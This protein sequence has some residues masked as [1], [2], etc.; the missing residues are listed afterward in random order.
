M[1]SSPNASRL[2]PTFCIHISIIDRNIPTGSITAKSTTNSRCIDPTLYINSSTINRQNT[3]WLIRV[4][5]NGRL[6]FDGSRI[7][8]AISRLLSI[9][10]QR[11]F[12]RHMNSLFH[13]Q[14][15]A[16]TQN[17]INCA[18]HF[19]ALINLSILIYHIPCFTTFTIPR[20][21]FVLNNNHFLR[22]I[23]TYTVFITK[24]TCIRAFCKA[25]ARQHRTQHSTTKYS[26]ATLSPDPSCHSHFLPPLAIIF[27]IL[28]KR[29]H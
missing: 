9:N 26:S 27:D 20:C 1:C 2:R 6:L 18:R 22:N 17:K 24:I 7:Y 19:H 23:I 21:C 15:H 28:F 29:Y 12:A 16:V 4:S 8:S 5:A 10:R 25:R 11:I 14:R 13:C 3:A